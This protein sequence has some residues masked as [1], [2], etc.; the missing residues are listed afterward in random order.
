MNCPSNAKVGIG[1]VGSLLKEPAAS[2]TLK[3][4]PSPYVAPVIVPGAGP[5]R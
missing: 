5:I 2:G 3:F 4:L 1:E